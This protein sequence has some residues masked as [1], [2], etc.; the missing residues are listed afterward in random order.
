MNL[1]VFLING[2]ESIAAM[3]K[4]ILYDI[5]PSFL[6]SIQLLCERYASDIRKSNAEKL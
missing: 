5:T 6:D 2:C 3:R 4:L 1:W